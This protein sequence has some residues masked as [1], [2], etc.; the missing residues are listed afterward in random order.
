VGEYGDPRLL[1]DLAGLAERCGWDA[2][3]IWDHVAYREPGWEV[4]IPT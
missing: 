1:V 4:A 3:F 2:V